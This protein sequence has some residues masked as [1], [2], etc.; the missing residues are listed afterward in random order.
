[1]HPTV[2]PL[3][4]VLEGTPLGTDTARCTGCD[5]PIPEGAPVT[6]Y[7]ARASDETRWSVERCYC[8]ACAPDRVTTPTIGVNE[9]LVAGR[10]ATRSEA[11]AQAHRPVLVEPEVVASSGSAYGATF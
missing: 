9:R 8:E 11:A 2:A 4:D 5:D 7:A 6:V 1:M 3:P 10:V